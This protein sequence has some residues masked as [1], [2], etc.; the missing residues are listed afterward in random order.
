MRKPFTDIASLVVQRAAP[1]ASKQTSRC[2]ML[3]TIFAVSGCFHALA[4]NHHTWCSAYGQIRYY[5]SCAI[6]VIVEESVI[7]VFQRLG[8]DSKGQHRGSEVI[9]K[10]EVKFKGAED[11]QERFSGSQRAPLKYRM[12]GYAW[13]FLFD[14]WATSK[15]IYLD[16]QCTW[17]EH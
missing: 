1:S 5:M 16:F 10:P 14:L 13:V 15:M 2:C 11:T 4:T 6:A 8:L 9:P 7:S 12:I 3:M 17:Q